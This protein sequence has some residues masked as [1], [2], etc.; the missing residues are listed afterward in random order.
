M[1]PFIEKPPL[2]FKIPFIALIQVTYVHYRRNRKRQLSK[3]DEKVPHSV[4]QK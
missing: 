1:L 4:T 2:N 3:T